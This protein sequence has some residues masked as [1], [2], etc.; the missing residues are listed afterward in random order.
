MT[1]PALSR[2]QVL[3]QA[4]PLI[5]ANA[6]TPALGLADSAALGHFGSEF[7]LAAVALGSLVFNFLYW[8]LGFLRMGTTGFVSQAEGAGDHEETLLAVVRAVAFGALFGIGLFFLRQ[9]VA[10][11]A[12]RLLDP[13]PREGAL[14][15]DYLMA[16]IWGAPAALGGLGGTG[17]LIALGR[18]K[19]LLMV[20][21]FE[22]LLNLG[23]D[24]TFVGILGWG[25]PGVGFGTA[26]AEWLG[27]ALVL[28]FSHRELKR[29]GA[30]SRAHS[31]GF[32]ARLLAK[33][34]LERTISSNSNIMV[35]TLAMIA[36]FTYFTRA[37]AQFGETVLAANHLLLQYISLS[38]FFLDGFAHVAESYVGRALGGRERGALRRAIRTTSEV[39]AVCAVVLFLGVLFGGE[40]G[41]HLL[42]RHESITL[43]AAPHVPT[44]ALYVL[45]S[46]AAFQLDGIFIGASATVAMRNTALL[47][48]AAFLLL[49][50]PLVASY[51]NDGL[52][53]AFVVYVV[54]RGVTLGLSLPKLLKSV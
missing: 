11:S 41:L 40:S 30:L 16:R 38:A 48:V 13:G 37:G 18:S 12:M 39:A 10:E 53:W 9:P 2:R 6:S 32:I 47:S 27:C 7:D 21:L 15:T 52:W 17:L 43:A 14:S 49:A 3:R 19:T 24:V 5:V 35:R 54:V 42:T 29:R 45:V 33:G 8:S 22:N 31:N 50:N 4:W 36:G 20:R 1:L 51:G 44:V 23:L 26:C 46:V 28:G 25:A 34:A